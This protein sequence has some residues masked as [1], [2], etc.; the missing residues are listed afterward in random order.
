MSSIFKPLSI[1]FLFQKT[2]YNLP[3]IHS[4]CRSRLSNLTYKWVSG[5][6][7]TRLAASRRKASL[8]RDSQRACFPFIFPNEEDEA[9]GRSEPAGT[10]SCLSANMRDKALATWALVLHGC[11]FS[12]PSSRD[13]TVLRAL[14]ASRRLVANRRWLE[15]ACHRFADCCRTVHLR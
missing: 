11:N 12:Y 10:S 8:V 5:I 1:R 6:T 13:M 15:P 4:V 14:T 7:S 2:L 9:N 3:E